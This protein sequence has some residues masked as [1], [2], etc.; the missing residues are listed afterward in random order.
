MFW[1]IKTSTTRST[2]TSGPI[3]SLTS[4]ANVPNKVVACFAETGQYAKIIVYA[5]RVGYTP[6]Y[7]P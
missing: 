2:S 4:C 3:S 7:G 5:K 6:D 1:L